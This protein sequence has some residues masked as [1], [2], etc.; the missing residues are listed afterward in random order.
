MR[1]PVVASFGILAIQAWRESSLAPAAKA[2]PGVVAAGGVGRGEALEF[3]SAACTDDA[4][5]PDRRM[6]V[7]ARIARWS[8]V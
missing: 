1:W 2:L 4:R 6:K 5:M 8:D 7:P 3:V